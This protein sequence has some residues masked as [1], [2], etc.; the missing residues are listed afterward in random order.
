MLRLTPLRTMTR[1]GAMLSGDQLVEGAADVRRRHGN[2]DSRPVVTEQDEPGL[3]SDGFLVAL[4]RLPGALAVESNRNRPKQLLDR[5][6]VAVRKAQRRK[7]PERDRPAVRSEEH[8]SELQSRQYL[9]CRLLLEKKNS[10]FTA[11]L[12]ST[13]AA[14]GRNSFSSRRSTR[15]NRKEIHY[16]RQHDRG[17]SRRG[18][19]PERG[20]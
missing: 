5:C 19:T 4:Q 13:P 16:R 18:R 9:V 6:G 2:V 7:Q 14:G 15:H 3:A 12:R 17:S 8:T 10:W 11:W 20:R 1:I